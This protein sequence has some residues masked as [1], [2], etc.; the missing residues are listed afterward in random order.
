M[1][2]PIVGLVVGV[3]V[4]AAERPT[5]SAFEPWSAE[6]H[7]YC[8]DRYRTFDPRTGTFLGSD[9]NRHFCSPT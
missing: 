7:R 5:E 9:G 4:A 2:L 6:W 8:A 3:I 1:S